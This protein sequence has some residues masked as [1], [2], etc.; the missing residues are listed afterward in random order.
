MKRATP[1]WAILNYIFCCLFTLIGFF[2]I[3]KD[4]P[5]SGGNTLLF[6]GLLGFVSNFL[7]DSAIKNYTSIK[8]DRLKNK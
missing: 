3:I 6:I 4:G 5:D 1:A 8:K 2:M 7:I